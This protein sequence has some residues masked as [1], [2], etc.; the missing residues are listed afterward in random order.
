MR[1]LIIGAYPNSI[2]GFRG[3]LIKKFV[4]S[5]HQVLV[6]TAAAEQGV[7]DE[8]QSLGAEFKSY[9]VQRNGINPFADIKTFWQL[10]K[11]IRKFKPDKILAYTIKPVIWGGLAVKLVSKADFYALITGLGYA[12][13]R[14]SF[15]RNVVNTAVQFLYRFA[16]LSAKGVIFQNEDNRSVFIEKKIVPQF[17]TYRVYGSGVNLTEYAQ[18][19]LPKHETT[20]LLIARLLGDKGIREYIA[21][22]RRVKEQYPKIIFQLL[23][24]E[25]SSPDRIPFSEIKAAEQA[26]IIQ[27][28]GE[29]DNV[30]PYL[31][32][33]HIYTLPSY[34]E[35]LPRTVLE[36]MA[37]GRPILTTNACGCRDTVIDNENGF[38]VPVKD[39]V[40]LANKMVWFIE[41]SSAWSSMA[42]AG[43]K[44]AMQFFDVEQV[45][46][47]LFA[48]M[49]IK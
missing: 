20:F 10:V 13:T 4:D 18:V 16:L 7:I 36:A 30:L 33:C 19:A 23:G 43:R 27:Y 21:A 15:L 11:A 2:V 1:V 42:H 25:D 8:V 44:Y 34:H 3:Q 29:T 41:N 28:L 37:V 31:Q 48:I 6:M 47:E 5:G 24:P 14:G 9:D 49:K 38:L 32:K 45:N 40:A 35:G 22:A 46:N 17:K 12:F 39:E 26:G